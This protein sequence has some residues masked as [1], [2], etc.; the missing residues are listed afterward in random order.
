M[1]KILL[2]A[3]LI[4]GSSGVI[5][6]QEYR[7]SV[8]IHFRQ[9]HHDL[10]LEFSDN[11]ASLQRITDSLKAN[12]T[13][14]RY[15]YWIEQI[16]IQGTASPEGS[17][18]LN[19]RLSEQR[20]Q[21]L[22]N[23]LLEY[24][25]IPEDMMNFQFVGRDWQ[26]L[27][28]LVE[29][30]DNVP[31]KQETLDMLRQIK[32]RANGIYSSVDDLHRIQQL[33]GGVPYKYMYDNLFPQLRASKMFISFLEVEKP[34]SVLRSEAYQIDG[35]D[36]PD[37]I[38]AVPATV[39]VAPEQ[40]CKPFYM[41]LKTNMLYDA[42]FTPNVGI[43]FYLGRR[44]SIGANWMYAWWDNQSKDQ[45]W[46]IYGGDLEL[47]RY[48][49]RRSKEK[50]LTGHH[51]GLYGQIATYDFSFGDRGYMGGEPGGN[52]FDKP[53]YGGGFAY[54]YALPVAKRLNIDFTIGV[55][56]L[57]GEYKEYLPIDDCYV[58]QNTKQRHWFGP[59]KAE[60]SL[61]WLIGCGNI[62]QKKGGKW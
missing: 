27:I 41:A 42:A 2:L 40:E 50:P 52:I 15:R 23:Y 46:R 1:K 62:N 6:A 58:W 53:S 12:L 57:G 24:N 43:E 19:R 11:R 31:Y 4:L 8:I 29:A 61:V 26:G 28:R 59:T 38:V 39:F 34:S 44:W 36:M 37:Q 35:K 22:F 56:Y 7:D 47:R 21:T 3:F 60:I 14:S 17:V 48:V 25:A 55:G 32:S 20:A 33:R 5:F 13:D 51:I 16:N 45:F 54:G 18:S 49:G 30:D 10:D 9:G